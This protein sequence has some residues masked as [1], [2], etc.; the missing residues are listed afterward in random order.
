MEGGGY[1]GHPVLPEEPL[2]QAKGHH[3]AG[4]GPMGGCCDYPQPIHH[5]ESCSRP[6]KGEDSYDEALQE[7]RE[8]H[9]WVLEATHIL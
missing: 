6:Q 7:A 5:L 9:Q 3:H 4:G 1:P 2:A 8:A